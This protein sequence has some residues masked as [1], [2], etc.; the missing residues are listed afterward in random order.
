MI[1]ANSPIM[2]LVTQGGSMFASLG[3]REYL[4]EK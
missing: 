1:Q 3:L 2:P 4:T